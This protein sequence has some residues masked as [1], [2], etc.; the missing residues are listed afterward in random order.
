VLIAELVLIIRIHA[1]LAQRAPVVFLLCN[2]LIMFSIY[3]MLA[4]PVRN[5]LRYGWVALLVA[6]LT[7]TR[8]KMAAQQEA[9]EIAD[10]SPSLAVQAGLA[11]LSIFVGR[12]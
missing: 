6:V 5:A 12:S 1:R 9:A 8:S 11:R 4:Y 10:P 3:M 7:Y 2:F